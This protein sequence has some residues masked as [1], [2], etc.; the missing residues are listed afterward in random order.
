MWLAKRPIDG[1][2]VAS[3]VALVEME[4]PIGPP[5]R[6]RRAIESHRRV[7]ISTLTVAFPPTLVSFKW[8]DDGRALAQCVPFQGF[9]FSFQFGNPKK[10]FVSSQLVFRHECYH[11]TLVKF[12]AP[13]SYPNSYKFSYKF[14]LA[15]GVVL[16]AISS[17]SKCPH[18]YG[19]TFFLVFLLPSHCRTVSAKNATLSFSFR[20]DLDL[21]LDRRARCATLRFRV[22]SLRRSVQEEKKQKRIDGVVFELRESG[23]VK[24][25]FFQE[26]TKAKKK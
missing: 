7:S 20:F 4:P 6:S 2:V 12:R 19:G 17:S 1:T 9:F 24:S 23:S 11:K 8:T 26:R 25:K 14:T 21:F 22:S 5:T 16:F 18:P 3:R 10:T 13:F 15:N